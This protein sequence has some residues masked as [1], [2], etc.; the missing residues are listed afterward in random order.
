MGVEALTISVFLFRV[1]AT[2][3][4]VLGFLKATMEVWGQ[5]FLHLVHLFQEESFEDARKEWL[6]WLLSS[7]FRAS[8]SCPSHQ[9]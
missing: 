2:W 1:V 3:L 9:V 4:G 6:P 7:S 5:L 8:L